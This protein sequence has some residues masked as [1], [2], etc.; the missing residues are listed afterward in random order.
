MNRKR[1][2]ESRKFIFCEEIIIL[3][4]PFFLPS[5]LLSALLSYSASLSLLPSLLPSFLPS[6]FLSYSASPC[7]L[8]PSLLSS[9]Y[10][11]LSFPLFLSHILI[12][13]KSFLVFLP[14]MHPFSL[15]PSLSFSL[16]SFIFYLLLN[17]NTVFLK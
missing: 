12:L 16:L 15:S 17:T 3:R 2:G 14:H 13:L 9:H 1:V 10:T 8:F 6:A 4:S 11:S 7:L 5:F